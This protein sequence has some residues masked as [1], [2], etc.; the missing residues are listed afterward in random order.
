MSNVW[1]MGSGESSRE[2]SWLYQKH[3][4]MLKSGGDHGEYDAKNYKKVWNRTDMSLNILHR[5]VTKVKPGDI[6]LMRKGLRAITL[7][8]AHEKGYSWNECFDDIYGWDLQHTQRVIW[9][10]HLEDDFKKLQKNEKLFAKRFQIPAFTRIKDETVLKKIEPLFKKCKTRPLKK[11]PDKL[12]HPLTMDELGHE[13]FSKGLPNSSVDAVIQALQRQRRLMKWYKNQDG[14]RPGEHEVVAHLIIPI[15]LALGWS[16]Q[17]LAVEWKKI[18]L[19]G[20]S[21]TPTSEATCAL[22]CEAKGLKHG[23]MGVLE[24]AQGYVENLKLKHCKKILL[25]GGSRFYLHEKKQGKWNDQPVGYINLEKIRTNHIAPP[26]TNA[27][28]TIIA[29]TPSGVM[30]KMTKT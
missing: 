21:E 22:V 9:Q 15:L 3:D 1:Q 19:A 18:D 11:L 23:L 17:L 6:I 30:R 13:L 20:F 27:V 2:F 12:P 25:A 16:E 14:T 26:N 8:I 7:G 24:Q 29:L 28:D 4:V 10:D 5:F